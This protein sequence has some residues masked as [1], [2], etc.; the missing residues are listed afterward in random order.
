[1]GGAVLNVAVPGE[2]RPRHLVRATRAEYKVV[3]CYRGAPYKF[4]CA[5]SLERYDGT[6]IA[7]YHCDI[8][9][10]PFVTTGSWDNNQTPGTRPVLTFTNGTRWVMPPAHSSQDVGVNWYPVRTIKNC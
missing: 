2:E 5:F 1:M 6:Y 10:I 7:M 3:V 9:P 8:Y 4:F